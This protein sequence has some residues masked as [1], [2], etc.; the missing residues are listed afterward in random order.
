MK[1]LLLI[2]HAKS[3]WNDPTQKDF[4]RPLNNRGHK[5]APEM[6]HRLVKKGFIPQQLVSSPAMRAQTTAKYF[7]E[8]FGIK[9]SEIQNEQ[10]IYEGSASSL[11]KV[12]NQLDNG[13]DLIALF[14]HNPGLT[15]IAVNLCGADIYNIPT[16][17]MVLI[18]FPFDEWKMVSNGTGKMVFF[19]YPKKS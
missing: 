9:K 19:D 6:A 13:H 3:D 18:E 16:C 2:R 8:A 7:A 4:D 14:G 12:I 10:P 15:T 17:G 5:N 1:Q 11:L